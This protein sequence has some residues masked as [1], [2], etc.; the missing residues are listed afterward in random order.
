MR[1]YHFLP[2]KYGIDD[3]NR[4]RL[5]I[6]TLDDLNDPF[7]LWAVAQPDA[8]LRKGLR[9][10]RKH[11]ASHYGM[12]CFSRGWH[13]PLLWS[14]YGDKHRGMV[15]GFDV[16]DK[17]LNKVE[18]V[19]DRPVLKTVDKDIA[20]KLKKKFQDWQ[21]EDELR[22]FTDLHGRDPPETGLYFADFGPELTL[23]KV[24][25]GPLSDTAKSTI[26]EAVGQYEAPVA[27]TKAR[28]AFKTFQV[29][30]NQQGFSE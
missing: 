24:I 26:E 22:V 7:D 9:E 30:T 20:D 19:A 29:V 27:L 8:Q 10:Y 21:Y 25:S 3:V 17:H 18:Y 15:L 2:A 5:K 1:V 6:A 13:N 23:R 28:L 16:T 12:L 4:R 14:H 11:L